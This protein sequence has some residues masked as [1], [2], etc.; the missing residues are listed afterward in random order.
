MV[1][2]WYLSEAL[3]LFSYL[4][5]RLFLVDGFVE[6]HWSTRSHA[7]PLCSTLRHAAGDCPQRRTRQ[8]RRKSVNRRP[9]KYW[10]NLENVH[11]EFTQFWNHLNVTIPENEAPPI[12]NEGLLNH[13][14]RHDLRY[15]IVSYGGRKSLSAR[16][17]GARIMPG[18]WTTAVQQSPELGQLLTN[19]TH[20]LSHHIPPLSP[21]QK[22]QLMVGTDTFMH[23]EARGSHR[24]GR[25][26]KGYGTTVIQDL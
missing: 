22:K 14:D 20:G 25:N 15:A 9:P 1:K 18:K 6:R 10:K 26:R 23:S 13:F 8:I 5:G 12:P 19:A 16:L 21:Q 17:G 4:L 24:E 7:R 11:D 2:R 3:C